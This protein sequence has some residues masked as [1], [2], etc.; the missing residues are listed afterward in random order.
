MNRGEFTLKVK[1][2]RLSVIFK[3]SLVIAAALA[4]LIQLDPFSGELNW[5]SLNYYTLMTNVL[6]AVYFFA[7]MVYEG[8]R[9]G[10]LLP[11]LKGAVVLGITITGLVYH[12]LLSG[13]YQ[14]QGTLAL[15]NVLLHYI[16]PL[17]AV[18]DWLLFSDKGH[19]RWK[20]PFLWLLVPDLYFVYVQIRVSMG[21]SLGT[22]GNRYIYPFINVDA[23]GWGKVILNGLL[24]NLF[25]V[26]LGF[27][28]VAI[29]RFMAR[30]TNR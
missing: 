23:L 28:F 27:V 9:G 19:Y 3:L 29:D 5:S 1:N 7:A 16:V 6:C 25:F 10:T 8:Q 17:M 30:R 24:L 21:A 26:L 12:F 11:N 22:G 20:S 14:A 18:I 15:S 2:M 4:I 13:S